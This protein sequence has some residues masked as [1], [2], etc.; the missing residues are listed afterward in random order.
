MEV[1][2]LSHFVA[3]ADERHFTRAARRMHIVQ[4]G[5]STSIRALEQQVGAALFVRSTRRVE[6]TEAGRVLL[7]E[8]RRILAA[9][10]S[11]RGAVAQVQ[12]LLRGKLSI[13]IPQSLS[14]YFD[15]PATLG[16]FRAAHPGVE[17]RLR[18]AGAAV[19][20]EGIA[21]SRLDLAFV[22]L[23]GRVPDGL[24]VTVLAREPL[25]LACAPSHRL[26][27]RRRVALTDLEGETFVD[28]QEDW[29]TRILVDRAF[30][31]ARVSR[32]TAFDVNDVC[33]LFELVAHGLGIALVPRTLNPDPSWSVLHID[34]RAP[35]PM[36]ELA[37]V[38]AR[39]EPLSRAAQALLDLMPLA[40]KPSPSVRTSQAR[41]RRTTLRSG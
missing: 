21:D 16:R 8:A 1:K 20:L 27:S 24:N 37:L 14:P 19:L 22:P 7:V 33:T 26:A 39:D 11:A 30:G 5:L 10:E 31:A 40:A 2:Q 18:Q 32:R 34:L 41:G 15:L 28:F 29:G 12:G 17:I 36:W 35:V 9:I 23:P 6:L 4:S 38:T 25:T 3:V 13:G